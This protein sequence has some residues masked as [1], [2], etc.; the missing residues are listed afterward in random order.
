M[1][2]VM[3]YVLTGKPDSAACGTFQTHDHLEQGALPGAVGA[4]DGEYL[5]IVGPYVD[6][7]HG[8]EAAEGLRD[9][10]QLEKGHPVLYGW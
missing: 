4:D 7:V 1:R 10:L 2:W 8:R 3:G 9:V 6:P 5:A